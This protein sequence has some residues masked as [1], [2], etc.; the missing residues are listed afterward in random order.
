MC[1]QETC[2]FCLYIHPNLLH[3]K[4]RLFMRAGV[5]Q[6]GRAQPCHG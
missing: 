6:F 5:A 4:V 2:L 3:Y 1:Y